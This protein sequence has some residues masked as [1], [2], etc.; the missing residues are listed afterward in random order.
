MLRL[1]CLPSDVFVSH[2]VRAHGAISSA[3]IINT[4][5]LSKVM[6]VCR[7]NDDELWCTIRHVMFF[8][9]AYFMHL[10]DVS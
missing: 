2:G 6:Y 10:P 5:R 9:Y 7:Y 1:D 4:V 3:K 8:V